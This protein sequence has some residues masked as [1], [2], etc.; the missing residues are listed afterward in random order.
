MALSAIMR[1][2]G[3]LPVP[4]PHEW[5]GRHRGEIVGPAWVRASAGPSNLING[6]TGW[7]GKE[8]DSDLNGSNLVRRGGNVVRVAPFTLET[9]MSP[10]DGK[11]VPAIVYSAE[12]RFPVNRVIDEF[13]V[14]DEVCLLCLTYYELP[15]MRAFRF[16]FLLHKDPVAT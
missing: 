16:P 13:R 14:L 3:E 9:R 12:N 6:I 2:F 8:I 4:D 15:L 5:V 11:R 1:R 10:V 7:V